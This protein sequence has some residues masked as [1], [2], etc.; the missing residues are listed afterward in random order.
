MELRNVGLVGNCIINYWRYCSKYG[1]QSYFDIPFDAG[2]LQ[3][4][5][6]SICSFIIYP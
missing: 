1:H 4:N 5:I 3:I 2:S 6:F